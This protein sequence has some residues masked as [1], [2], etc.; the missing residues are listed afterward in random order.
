MSPLPLFVTHHAKHMVY[1]P[2]FPSFE[3]EFLVIDNSKGE[4]LILGFDFLRNFNTCIHWRKGMITFNPDYEDSSDPFIPLINDFSCAKTCADL[5]LLSSRNEVLK[6]LKEFGEDNSVSSLHVFHGNMD[7]LP[8][9]YCDSPEELWHEEE[10]P[11][12]IETMMK[13]FPSDYHQYLDVFFKVKAEKV[14]P[15]SSC[16]HHIEME[17][18]LPPVGVIYSL[19]NQE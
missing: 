14:P 9:S 11:E 7:L 12:G 3:W 18:Y 17:G 8:S 1:L 13:A 16:D 19:S 15:H 6:E 10:D 5:S 2:S 4:D